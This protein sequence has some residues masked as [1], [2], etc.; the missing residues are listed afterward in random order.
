MTL[1]VEQREIGTMK[2]GAPNGELA[3]RDR[4]DQPLFI[5]LE[6]AQLAL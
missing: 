6:G 1:S 3:E 4:C 2:R 5:V